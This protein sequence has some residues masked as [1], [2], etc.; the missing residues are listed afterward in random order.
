MKPGKIV[1]LLHGRFAGSKA[2]IL[3]NQDQGTNKHSYG[4]CVVAGIEKYPRKV[5]KRMDNKKIAKKSQ[6][7]VFIKVVNYNHLMPTRYTL[8]VE[9]V[10]QNID[11][12]AFTVPGAAAEK[13]EARTASRK[14]VAKEFQNRYNAGKNRWFFTALRF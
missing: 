6:I 14:A 13:P 11:M 8:D 2:V 5:T 9:N 4:H 1:I 3:Q 7:S 12:S 10:K